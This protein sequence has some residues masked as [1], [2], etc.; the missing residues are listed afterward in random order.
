MKTKHLFIAVLWF[1]ITTIL[2]CIPGKKLPSIGWFQI[3]QVDKLVHIVIFGLLCFLWCRA[4]INKKYF[5]LMVL[6]MCCYGIIMEFVQE[7]YIPNRSFDVG[8]IYADC[9]GSLAAL[10]LLKRY[11]Q[12]LN[13]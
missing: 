2:L 6:L 8:D 5:L 11:P 9:L 12:L 1:I 7:N 3:Y 13:Y 4:L 10:L